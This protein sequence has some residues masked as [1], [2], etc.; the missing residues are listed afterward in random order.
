[1]HGYLDN[2]IEKRLVSLRNQSRE[3][4]SSVEDCPSANL[5][6]PTILIFFS[7]RPKP[8]FI[9]QRDE[10][11]SLD[12]QMFKINFCRECSL[13]ILQNAMLILI[14]RSYSLF[15]YIT[16]LV[17]NNIRKNI[18]LRFSL[19]FT[20]KHECNI[21]LCVSQVRVIQDQITI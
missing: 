10:T 20:Q 18:S 6:G 8:P 2:H 13:I 3:K 4:R 17:M 7:T 16:L 5:L 21:K 9:H 11:P 1:M 19:V 12:P 14:E 15:S